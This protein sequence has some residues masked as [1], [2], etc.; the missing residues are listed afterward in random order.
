MTTWFT[1]DWHMGHHNIIKYANRHPFSDVFV[2]GEKILTYYNQRVSDNDRVFFLGDLAFNPLIA[3][4]TLKHMK[5]KIHF[6]M[7]NHDYRSRKEIEKHCK[8]VNN[9]L[10]IEIEGQ[11]IV[12]C[13]YAMR[14]WDQSHHGSWQLYAHS[15]GKLPPQERQWDVGVDNNN[16]SPVSFDKIREII[17]GESK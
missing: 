1:A 7:G 3:E 2:M 11:K 10:T 17:T 15:H 5:G 4:H 6:I 13:H 9:L 12:L 8:S 14:V 16:Y